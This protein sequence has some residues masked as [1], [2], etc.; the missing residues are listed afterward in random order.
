MGDGDDH[1]GDGDGDE[2]GMPGFHGEHAH[3][4]DGEDDEAADGGDFLRV[5]V[6][7]GMRN[8]R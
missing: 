2:L 3:G 1:G 8:C 4:G 7:A 5:A 6:D